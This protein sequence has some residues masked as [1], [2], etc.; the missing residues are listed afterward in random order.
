MGSNDYQLPTKLRGINIRGKLYLIG[1]GPGKRNLITIAGE[2]CLKKSEVIFYFPP[3]EKI[4]NDIVANKEKYFFFNHSFNKIREIVEQNLTQ[5]KNVAFMVPGD[6]SIFSPFSGFMKIFEKDIEVVPGV[7]TYSY[8]SAKLKRILNACGKI[9]SISILS[10]RMLL[11]RKGNADFTRYTNRE[12]TLIIYMNILS[13]KMLQK[14]LKSV[15]NENT[16][17]IVGY[18]LTSDKEAII[19]TTVKNMHTDL[20][21]IKIENEK[22]VTIIVGNILEI[23]DNSKWWDSKVESYSKEGL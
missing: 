16:P 17:V 2:E 22:L 6:L 13:A 11:E 12:S 9:Y 20:E 23:L 18:N 4:F 19:K 10:T 1:C 7:G 15:Y 14:Q 8:L 3:Y 5:N 21:R